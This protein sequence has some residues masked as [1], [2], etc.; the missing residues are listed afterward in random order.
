MLRYLVKI[1]ELNE[2]NIFLEEKLEK[3]L[4]KIDNLS[5]LKS[6]FLWEGPS[7]TS[8]IAKYDE[9]ITKLRDMSDKIMQIIAFVKSY[10]SN[11]DEEYQKLKSKYAR[12]LAEEVKYGTYKV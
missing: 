7:K 1:N 11:Y 2:K 5:K 3:I 9:Y 8:F 12:L 10:H 6:E 4:E